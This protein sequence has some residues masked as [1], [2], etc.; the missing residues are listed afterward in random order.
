MFSRWICT[1]TCI[2]TALLAGCGRP[3]WGPSLPQRRPLGAEYVAIGTAERPHGVPPAGDAAGIPVEPTDQLTLRTALALALARN[4]ELASFGWSVREAEAQRLQAG[5]LPNPEL[6]AEFENFGGSGEFRGTRALETTI[7]LGQLIELGSKREKRMRLADQEA[8]L[9]GWDYE[10]KR[11]QVLTDVAK[12]F[13]G[14]LALQ[15]KLELAREGSDLAKQA[16]DVVGKQVDAGKAAPPESQRARVE[17]ASARIAV[18][19]AERELAAARHR[20]AATWGAGVPAFARAVGRLEELVVPPSRD[21]LAPKLAQNPDVARWETERARR[22]ASLA[23][24]QARAVPD[25]K[26][27]VGYRHF[28]ETE[29]NDRA[30]L[31]T[32]GVPLPLFDRNQGGIRKA[33]MSLLKAKA[34]QQAARV[35]ARADFEE[36]YQALAGAHAEAVSL[37]EEV[38]PAA[39]RTYQVARESF[40]Q[41]KSGYLG[42]LDAQRTLIEAKA[43]FVEALASYHQAVVTVEGLIGE[44]VHPSDHTKPE[45][46]DKTHESQE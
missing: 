26:L 5:L 3:E 19:R 28:R 2:L 46:K 1:K 44:A 31:M 39:R 16:L 17:V 29:D 30:L 20:L 41:G 36:G 25:V 23:L 7:A 34:E 27:G 14:V 8:K 13:A 45:A 4:P 38:L 9:A 40:R 12:Q 10:A 37:R 6:E 43:Q 42:L 24:E 33:Q 18:A 15:E 21:V 35:K 32:V 11:L 22:R